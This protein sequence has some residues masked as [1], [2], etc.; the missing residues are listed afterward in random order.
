MSESPN[1]GWSNSNNAPTPSQ[2]RRLPP[3]PKQRRMGNRI[4]I[5]VI[6]LALAVIV[7]LDHYHVIH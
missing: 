2:Q 4:G 6:L 5:G 3:T 7:L 1:A